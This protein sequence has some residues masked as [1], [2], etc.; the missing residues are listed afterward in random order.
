LVSVR[1]AAEALVAMAGGADLID[2]KEPSR[3]SLGAVDPEVLSEICD[4]VG[5]RLP[6]SAALGELAEFPVAKRRSDFPAN[7]AF[8][9]LGLAGSARDWRRRWQA[10]IADFPP[11]VRP[12][13]VAYADWQSAGAPSPFEVLQAASDAGC[14]YLLID[15]W[16][17]S[18]G[19]LLAHLTMKELHII[20]F[21]AST[22]NVELVLAGSLDLD[23][24]AQ[25]LR[26]A[27]AY[28]AVRGAAC[29]GGRTNAIE[30]ALVKR[31]ADLVQSAAAFQ[32]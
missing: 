21:R 11:H 1:S 22:G 6:I 24:I 31:L 13:A 29:L 19:S 14:P 18:R 4:A 9:K 30:R 3:G 16:D 32:V 25:V 20:G 7:L 12:V 27:P 2:V 23:S 8:A 28:V 5:G 15:T 26:L 10:A 17:K